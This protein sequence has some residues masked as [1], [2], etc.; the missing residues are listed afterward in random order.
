MV[1]DGINDAQAMAAA[2]VGVA[3]ATAGLD[4]VVETADVVL[5]S[6]GLGRLPLLLRHARRTVRVIHQNVAIALA[7][8]G[9]FLLLALAGVATLW[10]A[11]AGDM[12]ATLLV[13]FNGL[14]LLRAPG[15]DDSLAAPF[16]DGTARAAHP[17]RTCC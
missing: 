9:V 8:K 12:G 2:T 10:M 3:M 15:A 5:M 4:V 16:T 14:R 13:T 7:M 17:G 6:G 1:G 11:V